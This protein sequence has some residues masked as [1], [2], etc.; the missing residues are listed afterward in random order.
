MLQTEAEPLHPDAREEGPK[1]RKPKTAREEILSEPQLP[2]LTPHLAS[3][4]EC[5]GY[6]A[7]ENKLSEDQYIRYVASR[8]RVPTCRLS[9]L[10]SYYRWNNE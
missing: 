1:R 7:E 2:N 3:V 8:M 6:L 4:S 10:R 9:K 5:L